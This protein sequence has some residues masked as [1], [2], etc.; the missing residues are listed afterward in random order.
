MLARS[1]A[2]LFPVVMHLHLVTDR[3]MVF[4]VGVSRRECAQ[5]HGRSYKSEHGLLHE[6]LPFF[7]GEPPC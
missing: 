2:A 3:V 4:I 6:G 1:V 5:R 7:V